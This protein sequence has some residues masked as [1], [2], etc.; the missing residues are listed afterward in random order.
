MILVPVVALT[1]LVTSM[2][3]GPVQ[4]LDAAERMFFD[5]WDSV[6]VWMSY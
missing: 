6:V 1:I 2:M 3:G 5:A 4:A